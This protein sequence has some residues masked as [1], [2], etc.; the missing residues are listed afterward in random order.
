MTDPAAGARHR[1]EAC[2]SSFHR[3]NVTASGAGSRLPDA[4]PSETDLT[5]EPQ[6]DPTLAAMLSCYLSQPRVAWP[7]LA[8]I[9]GAM[10]FIVGALFLPV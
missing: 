7:Y 9:I 5:H 4:I 6:S 2:S 1:E 3:A 8:L 10:A